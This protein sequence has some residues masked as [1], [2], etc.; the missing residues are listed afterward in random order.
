M[1]WGMG[2]K[3]YQLLA[4]KGISKHLTCAVAVVLALGATNAQAQFGHQLIVHPKAAALGNAV[5]AD[6]PGLM[7]M[8]RNPAGLARMEGRQWELGL[9]LARPTFSAE[10]SVPEEGC[11][12]F[13]IDCAENDPVA[14]TKGSTH[15]LGLYTPGIGLVKGPRLPS[16]GAAYS[17]GF[18]VKPEGSK[19]TFANGAWMEFAGGYVK[20]DDDPGRYM[21]QQVALQ[22]FTYLAP[23][24]A[25]EIDDNWSV[26]AGINFS[27]HGVAATQDARAPNML[28]GVGATLQDAFGCDEEQQEPL[29]PWL[30][31][32]GGKIGPFQDI[33]T[34]NFHAQETLSPSYRLGVL[35]EPTDWF[36]WGAQ[37]SSGD[38]MNLKGEFELD[39]TEDWSGFWQSVNSSV[40][41]AIGA[42]ILS[43]PSG[44]PKE[45]ANVSLKESHPQHFST[46]ISARVMPWLTLNVD[47]DYVD[48]SS[49]KF[50]KLEFDRE[51]EFTNAAR[52]LSPEKATPTSL[53]LDRNFT[54]IWNLGY[55]ASFHVSSRL[56]L[57]AGVQHRGSVIPKG[58][59]SLISPIGAGNLYGVGLG[60]Q[61]NKNTHIDMNASY[62]K[63]TQNVPANSSCNLNCDNIT[64]I[65]YNPY[66]GLDVKMETSIA[67][68]GISVRSKF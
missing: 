29:A 36:T 22:R 56:D 5:T 37:Y 13:G 50:L 8:R 48:L 20:D 16:T 44:V 60:Y 7:A 3:E 61:W 64:N 67:I 12:I 52:I 6:P 54:D 10:F 14:N 25:Y 53:R 42:A 21:G 23:T 24:V 59:E 47:A 46:G 43:L 33:G 28:V 68:L 17:G 66:A 34:I 30:A 26:G 1:M 41:G 19:L 11:D 65:V 39:Y 45:K 35:W 31:L 4:A 40:L 15:R 9:F 18:S 38:D 32:C 58:K 63:S 27:H 2:D 55:G 57:R 62:L 49:Q 51:L